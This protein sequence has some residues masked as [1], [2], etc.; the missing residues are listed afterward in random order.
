MSELEDVLEKSFYETLLRYNIG[1][2]Y[3][4]DVIKFENKMTFYLKLLRKILL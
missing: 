3:V 2:W 1:D 4:N